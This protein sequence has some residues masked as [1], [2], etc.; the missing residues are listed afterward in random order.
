MCVFNEGGALHVVESAQA[1][2]E[3][4]IGMNTGNSSSEDSGVRLFEMN[5]A[6]V[7]SYRN[8]TEGVAYWGTSLITKHPASWDHHRALGIALL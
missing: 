5:C 2:L 7:G 1:A 3:E 8:I 6:A 4:L